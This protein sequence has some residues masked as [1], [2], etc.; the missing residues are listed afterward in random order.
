MQRFSPTI[1][2]LMMTSTMFLGSASFEDG[3]A[4]CVEAKTNAIGRAI[5]CQIDDPDQSPGN[6]GTMDYVR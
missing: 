6:F 2:L 5:T 1:L 3:S 4:K